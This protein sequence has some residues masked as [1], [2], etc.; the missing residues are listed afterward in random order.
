[1]RHAITEPARRRAGTSVAPWG[2]PGRARRHPWARPCARGERERKRACRRE[3]AGNEA[4]AA[5]AERRPAPARARVRRTRAAAG[6]V[7]AFA[8]SCTAHARSRPAGSTDRCRRRARSGDGGTGTPT[9]LPAGASGA[10]VAPAAPLR[11]LRLLRR[12]PPWA[13]PSNRAMTR[14]RRKTLPLQHP[15][16]AT[17]RRPIEHR[18]HRARFGSEAASK[19]VHRLA[20]WVVDTADNLGLP[21]IVVDKKQASVFVF[22]AAASCGSHAR[23]ARAR[24]RRRL[25]AGHRRAPI[26]E[27]RPEERTTP[28]GR[29]VAEPG[30]NARA[31]TS[32]GSTT[33][34]PSRCTAC[35]P[36]N[37]AE[38]RLQRL[39]SPTVR[40]NRICYGCINL[41]AAFYDLCVRPTVRRARRHRLRAARDA[42]ARRHL[43]GAAGGTPRT[44]NKPGPAARLARNDRRGRAAPH[45]S[46]AVGARGAAAAHRVVHRVAAGHRRVRV[47]AVGARSCP[48]H[49][50]PRCGPCPGRRSPSPLGFV[51]P[52]PRGPAG[53]SVG[54]VLWVA[55]VEPAV[56]ESMVDDRV[57]PV[58]LPWPVSDRRRLDHSRRPAHAALGRGLGAGGARLRNGHAGAEG[59]RDARRDAHQFRMFCS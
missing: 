46:V 8:G 42:P 28:A 23:A 45:P 53:L 44:R 3:R 49:S 4:I 1:M 52:T 50:S 47:H 29:F 16:Q 39:A 57:V 22:D 17:R 43:P 11:S 9:T 51:R 55:L 5:R 58:V 27:I 38:R 14:A 15:A 6:G 13:R 2:E 12:G 41:P 32:S 48:N 31:K 33:T 40:D 35:A 24:A 37:P 20:D 18:P 56:P 34:P 36:T 30:F 7:L 21:F 25:G 54:L 10:R 59:K 19:D 26:A